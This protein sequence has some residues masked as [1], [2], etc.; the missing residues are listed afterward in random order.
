MQLKK[1]WIIETPTLKVVLPIH[2]LTQPYAC[3]QSNTGRLV[4]VPSVVVLKLSISRTSDDHVMTVQLF[5]YCQFYK[6]ICWLYLL[7][8]IWNFCIVSCNLMLFVL[9]SYNHRYCMYKCVLLQLLWTNTP[10]SDTVLTSLCFNRHLWEV[11]FN[12][13]IKKKETFSTTIKS[14]IE[15]IKATHSI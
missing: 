2:R 15:W 9:L 3:K 1:F 7:H 10:M 4:L 12:T 11:A 8:C 14:A 13:L 6:N 5:Q